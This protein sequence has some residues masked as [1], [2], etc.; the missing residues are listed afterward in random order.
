M[1]LPRASDTRRRGEQGTAAP[2]SPRRPSPRWTA[3]AE[4][5][6]AIAAQPD[7]TLAELNAQLDLI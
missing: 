1:D 3:D 4:R 6:R 7:L 5:L 2:T